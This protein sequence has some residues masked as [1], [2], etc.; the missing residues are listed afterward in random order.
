MTQETK[1]DL[2]ERIKTLLRNQTQD[3]LLAKSEQI[4]AKLY[5]LEAYI[6]AKTILFFA[7]FDGEVN[8]YPMIQY[9]L[10][11]GKAVALP[12]IHSDHT[13]VAQT[14]SSLDDLETGPLGISQIKASAARD[15]TPD[16]VDLVVVPGLAYD[17]HKN[18]LGRGGGFY[19]R[20]LQQLPS[21]T[22]TVGVAF[23]FQVLDNLPTD[24]HDMPVTHVLTN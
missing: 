20:Y 24:D 11:E 13:F 18:R 2:R 15:I 17:Q 8:T 10:D 4:A 12:K 21:D 19:D 14:L 5:V 1:K 7:S 9:A 16:Q 6:Q 3:A 23:D 22:P